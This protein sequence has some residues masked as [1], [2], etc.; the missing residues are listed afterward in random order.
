MRN[1]FFY[2]YMYFCQSLQGFEDENKSNFNLP[3]KNPLV[4]DENKNNCKIGD[5]NGSLLYQDAMRIYKKYL[6]K[7]TFGINRISEELKADIEKAV[8]N[9]NDELIIKYLSDAQKVV[10]KILENE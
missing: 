5:H 7:D 10:Y 6:L 2:L 8:M 1:F 3:K 4:N 9:E